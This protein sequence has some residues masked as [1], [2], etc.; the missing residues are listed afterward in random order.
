M[1]IMLEVLCRLKIIVNQDKSIIYILF[2]S[3]ISGVF[4]IIFGILLAE[5]GSYNEQT[6]FFHR[7]LG[8]ATTILSL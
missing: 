5:E 3:T 4:S 6:L 7:W 2:F 1:A 8:V